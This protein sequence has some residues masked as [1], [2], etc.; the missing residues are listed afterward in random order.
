MFNFNSDLFPD[1]GDFKLQKNFNQLI[2]AEGFGV[3]QLVHGKMVPVDEI[4]V[5]WIDPCSSK[6][7][8]V[9]PV[10]VDI[11]PDGSKVFTAYISGA[12]G[13][14]TNYVTLIDTLL[15]AGPNDIYYV[16]LDS[17]GGGIAAGAMIASAIWK[18]QAKVIT[19]ARGLCASAAALIHAAS[20]PGNNYVSEMG[21]LMIHMSSHNSEC[22][23][24]T[25]VLRDAQDQVRYVNENL[26][27]PAIQMGY[28]TQEELAAIQNGAEIYITAE[29]FKERVTSRFNQGESA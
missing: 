18:S 25:R 14:V 2:G 1:L 3:P 11:R 17:P 9:C 21:I 10:Y 6:K 28:I 27:V 20:K 26:L 5:D 12:I 23:L 16:M 22:I 19:I 29:E 4:S 7:S 8:S 15:A 24:S 13:D